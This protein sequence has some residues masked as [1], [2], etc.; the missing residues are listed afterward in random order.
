MIRVSE[1]FNRPIVMNYHG[2]GPVIDVSVTTW[3]IA[4]PRPHDNGK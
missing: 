1:S 3:E 2:R 4:P